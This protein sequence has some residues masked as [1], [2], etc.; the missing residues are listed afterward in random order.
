MGQEGKSSELD[1]GLTLDAGLDQFKALFSV[2]R[3]GNVNLGL[4]WSLLPH[5]Q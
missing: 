4:G 2:G 1:G 5:A 3:C